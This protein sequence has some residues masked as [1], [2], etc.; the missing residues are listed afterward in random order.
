MYLATICVCIGAIV[1]LKAQAEN[2]GIFI[3]NDKDGYTNIRESPDGK[4]KIIGK[5]YKHQLLFRDDDGYEYDED[6]VI[7]YEWQKN[8][9]PVYNNSVRGYIY[10]KNTLGISKL[11]SLDRGFSDTI[12]RAYNDS[13]EVIMKIVAFDPIIDKKRLTDK[14]ILGES[15]HNVISDPNTILGEIE[16]NYKWGKTIITKHKLQNYY[17][18]VWW[19]EVSIGQDGELYIHFAGG[20]GRNNIS[21]DAWIV[22]FNAKIVQE[23]LSPFT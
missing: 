17:L 19:M 10:K 22:I 13:V 6:G 23:I 21:Y 14:K 9:I 12:I 15:T 5:A 4:A 16:I 2:E 8:W 11:S 1:N 18:A 20:Q 3:I 7:E